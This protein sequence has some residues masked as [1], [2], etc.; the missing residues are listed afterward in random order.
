MSSVSEEFDRRLNVL[1]KV[2][3]AQRSLPARLEAVAGMAKKLVPSC[4][5]ASITLIVEGE[6]TTAAITDRIA[7]EIDLVQYTND[8]GPCLAAVDPPTAIRIDVLADDERF[9]R[10][11]AGAVELGVQSVLSL[12]LVASDM[13]VGSLNMYSQQTNAFDESTEQAMAPLLQYAAETVAASPLYASAVDTV[14]E[15][16]IAMEDRAIIARAVGVLMHLHVHSPSE[17]FDL[18]EDRATLHRETTR[19]A[20]ERVLAEVRTRDAE[21]SADD[22]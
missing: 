10:F 17:A 19:A 11:A 18:L 2:L 15:A 22:D 14:A 3:A 4:D 1:V 7:L 21:T 6:A 12:P 13:V 8:E 9:P 16:V 20:A 5:A